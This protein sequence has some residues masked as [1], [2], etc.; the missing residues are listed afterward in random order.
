MKRRPSANASSIHGGRLG[1][2][3]LFWD[4]PNLGSD[5]RALW[6]KKRAA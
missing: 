2:Y 6:R 3:I 5:F 4:N 1:Y